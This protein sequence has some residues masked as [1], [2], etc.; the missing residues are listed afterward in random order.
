[1]EYVKV[2]LEPPIVGQ[3]TA[4]ILQLQIT[5]INSVMLINLVALPQAKDA[6]QHLE[7]VLLIEEPLLPA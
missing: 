1:M 3:E 7:P 6:L 4:Q 2:M 5:L